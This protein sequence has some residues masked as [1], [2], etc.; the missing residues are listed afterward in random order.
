MT[1]GPFAQFT[2]L[3][4][5]L[6]CGIRIRVGKFA[7]GQVEGVVRHQPFGIANLPRFGVR[8]H[9]GEERI[10]DNPGVNGAALEGGAGVSRRQIDRRDIF[11]T[12]PG[13]LQRGHQQI[14]HVGAF[15][16]PHALAFKVGDTLNRRVF[17]HH[18]GF[19]FWVRRRVG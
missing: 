9:F 13:F 6:L 11:I 17:R 2:Q 16:E 8:F 7:A 3:I 19:G 5:H 18:D 10:P 14:V 12:Q 1:V 4:H 15:V